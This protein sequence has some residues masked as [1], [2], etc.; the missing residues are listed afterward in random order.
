LN[1]KQSKDILSSAK[2]RSLILG[3]IKNP[4]LQLKLV[5]SANDTGVSSVGNISCELEID[6][7]FVKSDLNWELLSK[8]KSRLR[9]KNHKSIC[10]FPR[11]LGLERVELTNLPRL[12]DVSLFSDL[13]Q[14]ALIYCPEISDVKCLKNLS[15]LTL[16]DC[17]K[18]TDVSDLG[19]IRYL[20]LTKCR[21]IRDTSALTNNFSLTV[22]DCGS[23]T[24]VSSRSR[25]SKVISLC[26]AV[27]LHCDWGDDHLS[28]ITFP[29]LR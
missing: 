13:K 24:T 5:L 23:T 14:L 4:K 20:S 10:Q 6:C 9:L 27:N 29:L 22:L 2:F 15:R 8:N 16:S 26:K 25:N 18:V 1:E 21:G 7:I 3:K 28:R 17:P 19:K 11:V 12:R